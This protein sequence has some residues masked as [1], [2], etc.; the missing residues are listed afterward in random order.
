MGPTPKRLSPV[1]R[2]NGLAA[3]RAERTG[4]QH[5][6]LVLLEK[7]G[8]TACRASAGPGSRPDAR[9]DAQCTIEVG[10][11]EVP[12]G[13]LGFG[14]LIFWRLPAFSVDFNREVAVQDHHV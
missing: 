3:R 13:V 5:K 1:A 4:L 6:P 2:S 10:S 14:R 11:W 9:P 12:S 8:G 7:N